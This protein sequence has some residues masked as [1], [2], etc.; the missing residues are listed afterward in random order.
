MKIELLVVVEVDE[1]A[2]TKK[3]QERIVAAFPGHSGSNDVLN[4]ARL[5]LR[6]A[7]MRGCQLISADEKAPVPD[8]PA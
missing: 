2:I 8:T 7:H 1:D 4:K 6:K 3:D 5:F